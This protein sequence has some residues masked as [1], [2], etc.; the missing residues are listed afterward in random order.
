MARRRR[1]ARGLPPRAPGA[2]KIRASV[3]LAGFEGSEENNSPAS[4]APFTDRYDN[5]GELFSYDP[6]R[7]FKTCLATATFIS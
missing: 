6:L 1:M 3:S 7:D 5:Y 4:K 2:P